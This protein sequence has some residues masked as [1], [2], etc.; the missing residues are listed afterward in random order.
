[1][2]LRPVHISGGRFVPNRID[3]DGVITS[4][5]QYGYDVPCGHCAECQQSKRDAYLLRCIAEFRRSQYRACFLTLTYANKH[6]PKYGSTSTPV[7][8]DDGNL[9][10]PSKTWY[11]SVWNKRHI[12]NFFKSLNERLIYYIGTEI[13]HLTRLETRNGR[14]CI[15][16]EW[17]NYLR[18]CP[19][20]VKYLCVCERGKADIYATSNGTRKGTSRPHY[21]SIVFITHPSLSVDVVL[22]LAKDL[23]SYG[24][25]YNIQVGVHRNSQG[26]DRDFMQSIKYVCKYVT[27]D[28]VEI[29]GNIRFKSHADELIHK[30]FV[31]TSNGLGDN[32]L[33]NYSSLDE[34]HQKLVNGITVADGDSLRVLPIPRYNLRKSPMYVT[35]NVGTFLSSRISSPYWTYFHPSQPIY[36]DNLEIE[37]YKYLKSETYLTEFGQRVQKSLLYKRADKFCN[38]LKQVHDSPSIYTSLANLS[39]KYMRGNLLDEVL[40]VDIDEF[41][42]FMLNLYLQYDNSNYVDTNYRVY[43]ELL[44]L[45]NTLK[46]Y[47]YKQKELSFKSTLSKAMVARPEL[48]NLFPL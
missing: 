3:S 10:A 39:Y 2:C 42:E 25:S 16:N 46:S 6:L 32:L 1:M 4:S 8:D 27:K 20:P 23:W 17:K 7:F 43:I 45:N 11:R 15:T 31:L 18:V 35:H 30:P 34:L 14:R 41:R 48:F 12:Q 26:L 21:H 33:D 28:T 24:L 40:S 37:T 29:C 44:A 38:L 13:L 19:R 22:R 47:K 9:V 36:V 5:I